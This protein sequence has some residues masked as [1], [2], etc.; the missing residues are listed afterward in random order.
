MF[1]RVSDDGKYPDAESYRDWLK[2]NR[3]LLAK[4]LSID[5]SLTFDELIYSFISQYESDVLVLTMNIHRHVNRIPYL[6]PNARY[7]HLLRDPRDVAH[8]CIGMGLCGHFYYGVDIW[9]HAVQ[10]WDKLKTH[11]NDDQYVEIKYE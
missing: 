1:D 8:S 9:K 10:S 5:E 2:T 3:I 6:F 4:G 7:L 11:L